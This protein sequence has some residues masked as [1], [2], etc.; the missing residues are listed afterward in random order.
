MNSKDKNKIC[1]L[2]H[3]SCFDLNSPF[4]YLIKKKGKN[5]FI[6]FDDYREGF[7][8]PYVA[9]EKVGVNY[10]YLKTFTGQYKI[11]NKIYKN[12]KTKMNVR[13]LDL[14]VKT[15]V[16]KSLK[17]VLKNNHAFKEKLINKIKFSLI[18]LDKA[19][20]IMIN[21]L[22]NKKKLIYPEKIK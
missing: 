9:E 7:H 14:K 17:K 16:D 5:L 2:P 1:N 20:N 3:K 22:R 11:K 10:R 6:G 19:F 4:G 21:D 13:K 12:F 8:F 18:N 15:K